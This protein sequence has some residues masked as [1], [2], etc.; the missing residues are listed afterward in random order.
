MSTEKTHSYKISKATAGKPKPTALKL[1][2]GNPGKRPLNT[3][4]PKPRPKM[5]KPPSFLSPEALAEWERVCEE[6]YEIGIVTGIDRAA[7]GTYCQAYG[8]WQ[9]A[10]TAVLAIAENDPATKG[11]LART[12]KGNVIQNPLVGIANVA[13]RDLMR[14]AIEFGMTPSARSR[15]QAET[16]DQ[17]DDRAASYF[18]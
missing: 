15:I 17:A 14:Y 3:K 8:R 9:Q 16:P 1:I 10:E 4:E 5:P 13:M 6:L 11:L 12:I 2:T 18:G 7:L